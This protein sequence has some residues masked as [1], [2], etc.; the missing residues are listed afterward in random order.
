[1]KSHL[2]RRV[3]NGIYTSEP[4]MGA[5]QEIYR[6]HFNPRIVKAR[7]SQTQV[8]DLSNEE[9]LEEVKKIHTLNKNA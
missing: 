4:I 2:N 6:E 8:T 1:M 7:F 3:L 9:Q 5:I